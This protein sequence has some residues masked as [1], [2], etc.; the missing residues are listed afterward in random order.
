MLVVCLGFGEGGSASFDFCDDVVGGFGPGEGFGVVVPVLGPGV[1]GLGQLGD[2]AEAV[3]G[4]G[5]AGE[6]GEPGFDEVEPRRRGR[7]EV[8]VPAPAPGVGEPG[9]NWLGFVG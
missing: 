5:F 8:Q 2:G 1:D 6:H 7:G 3:L 4:E 9:P